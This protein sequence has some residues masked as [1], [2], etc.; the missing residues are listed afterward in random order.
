MAL[1]NGQIT[2]ESMVYDMKTFKRSLKNRRLFGICGAIGDY[3]QWNV[4]IIRLIFFISIFITK[5]ASFILYCLAAYLIP[6]ET[7]SD[8][9]DE[10]FQK[11][12]QNSREE[13]TY[14]TQSNNRTRKDVT[15]D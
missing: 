14:Y 3:L 8:L 10:Q 13:Y 7:I 1:D 9:L 11:Y 5:G 2:V 12:S 6:S 15:P 4:T